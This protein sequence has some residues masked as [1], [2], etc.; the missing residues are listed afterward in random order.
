MDDVTDS[1]ALFRQ[2]KASVRCVPPPGCMLISAS[3]T[4]NLLQL[5]PSH[6]DA[7]GHLG[8]ES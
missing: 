7:I 2:M 1:L 6:I 8:F 4:E 5:F 3:D